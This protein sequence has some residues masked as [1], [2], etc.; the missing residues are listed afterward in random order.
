MLQQFKADLFR[1]LGHPV[2]I[3]IFELL[4][5]SESG[6]LTVS[7]LQ[8]QLEIEPSSVSQQLGVLRFRNLVTPRKEG[9]RVF[10]QVADDRVFELLDVARAIFEGQLETM[11]EMVSVSDEG[12][13]DE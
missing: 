2:R 5:A 4:R 11:Q 12:A 1:A 8:E 3:R 6:E 9:T 10:Y 13:G 7:Q